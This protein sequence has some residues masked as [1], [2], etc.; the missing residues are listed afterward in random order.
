MS[1]TATK[2]DSY[3]TKRM[4]L[5]GYRLINIDKKFKKDIFS[6]SN[7]Y[8]MYTKHYGSCLKIY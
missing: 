1:R 7:K 4:G 2:F 6:L 8:F 3:K 5:C